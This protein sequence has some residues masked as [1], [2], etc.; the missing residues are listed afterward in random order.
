MG[1]V[2]WAKD[3]ALS[4][5]DGRFDPDFITRIHLLPTAENEYGYD[6]FGFSREDIKIAAYFSR[7]LYRDYFRCQVH[8]I[9]NVPDGPVL[10][11]A[12]HSGHLPFDALCIAC[13]VM[14]D[15]KTPRVVRAMIERFVPN[16]PFVSYLLARW[17]QIIGSPEN[18]VRLLRAGEAILVFPE[19]AKGIGKPFTQRY[20]LQGFGS[21]FM[22]LA[23][24]TGCPIVPIAV[25]GAEEQAPA[26]NFKP[27]AKIVGTPNFPLMPLPPFF[28]IIPYPT[29]YRMYFGEPLTFTGDPDEE[30]EELGGLV[31]EVRN[32]IQSML[33][34][35]LKERKHVFW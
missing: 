31:R 28:P 2:A 16:L 34:T 25:I 21:G 4:W 29:R 12:N 3:R 22:R 35:G 24:E 1:L 30:E 6:S 11:V 14:F 8:G 20:Q 19:G 13:A 7:F 10:L 32:R 17:G 9:E 5:I 18:C 15:R 27:L 33:Y 26:F 23:L